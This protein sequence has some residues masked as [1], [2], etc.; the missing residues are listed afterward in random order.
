MLGEEGKM[1]RLGICMALGVSGFPVPCLPE[2]ALPSEADFFA[3]HPIVLSASRL[4]QPLSEAPA[5]VTVIDREE[6]EASGFIELVDL[7][8]LVPG[9]QVGLSTANNTIAVTY[10]GQSD[11]FPRRMEVLVDGRSVYNALL[12]VD[13]HDL[14]VALED[15]DRIEVVRGPS[16]PVYG[17]NA[18]IAT[19]N[20]IT[21]PRYADRG[22]FARATLGSNS[23]RKGTLRH[24]GN[25]KG[26]D[27]RL[28]LGYD[29]S[30]NFPGRN[31]EQLLRTLNLRGW[32]DVSDTDSLEIHLG[33][34]NGPIGRGGDDQ[35]FNLL[36]PNIGQNQVRSNYQQLR[37]ARVLD[38]R[39][40]TSVQFYH[41]RYRE[42]DNA[43]AG[44]LSGIIG[45][46]P[47]VIPDRFPGHVD[48]VMPW[49]VFDYT[50]ERYD[51]EWKYNDASHE[52]LQWMGGA[53]LRLD[54]FSSWTSL[55]R[56]GFV[57]DQGGRAF[58]NAAYHL[59]DDWVL[60]AGGMLEDGDLVHR[61]LSYRFTL[62]RQLSP[63]HALRAGVTR[64]IRKCGLNG[65]NL[66]SGL[67]FSN[68]DPINVF[69]YSP[70]NIKPEEMLA[71][72]IGWLAQWPERG[73]S[74]D[75]KLFREAIR[76]EIRVVHGVAPMDPAG[77]GA[78][79]VANGSGVNIIGLEGQ[80]QYRPR[81]GDLASLQ[82]SLARAEDRYDP[83]S[84]GLIPEAGR[85]P[86]LTLSLLL[87][88]TFSNDVQ[89]SLGYYHVGEMR[90]EGEG[91]VMLGKPP[92]PAYDRVDLR[93][94]KR[95]R[96][97]GEDVLLEFIA[98]N[99]GNHAYAEFRADNQFETRYFLRAS[100]QFN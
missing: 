55:S 13:W 54:R 36:G 27:Y 50:N 38:V 26:F 96:W 71:W 59:D 92:V 64:S 17:A 66:K 72:E 90:W 21:R 1:K 28:T 69:S 53:G 63:N 61:E 5:A 20:I 79:V 70:G 49:A 87:A 98:Q 57:Q 40:D 19:V 33:G 89:L 85:T 80:L 51:L 35:L 65:E 75:T 7:L 18:F 73:L 78:A 95:I 37:W 39:R 10:H 30:D 31:D 25:L 67:F 29:Q 100:L 99:I 77:D 6:I 32:Y 97:S 41:Q 23:T 93:L 22:W 12:T 9:F 52:R 2:T 44:L 76:R 81:H 88:H 60:N 4:A 48:E 83:I 8:R 42:E 47:A 14:G 82:Y 68:G 15:V 94:A 74:L 24:V 34:R 11:N 91:E 46:A 43:N 3:Q 84:T 56:T 62:N 58:A 16:S 86:H 45:V